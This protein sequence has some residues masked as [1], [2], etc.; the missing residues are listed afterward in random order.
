MSFE[1]VDVSAAGAFYFVERLVLVYLSLLLDLVLVDLAMCLALNVGLDLR[2]GHEIKM[3]AL[4]SVLFTLGLA[5]VL[6]IATGERLA[7]L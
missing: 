7:S 6:E 2:L 1:L 4:K 5:S 3:K